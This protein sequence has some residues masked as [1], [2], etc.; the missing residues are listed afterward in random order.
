MA[1]GNPFEAPDQTAQ[2]PTQGQAQTQQP[3]DNS[4]AG[5]TP[6]EQ[7]QAAWTGLGW[8]PNKANQYRGQ[9]QQLV[10]YMAQHGGGQWGTGDFKRADDWMQ[11]PSGK[12]WD[13]ITSGGQFVQNPDNTGAPGAGSGSDAPYQPTMGYTPWAPN[14]RNNALYNMLM[15]RA[16]EGLDVSAKDPVIANQVNAFGAEQDRSARNY[17]R[18]QAEAGGPQSN[19]SMEGR[20]AS[21]KAG[22]A[23]GQLQ[24]QLMQNERNARRQEIQAAISQ[25]GGM[26]SQDQMMALQ[27]ELAY[28][29]NDQFLN[30]MDLARH[31]QAYNEY[32]GQSGA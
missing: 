3:K 30:Q 26:L 10:D 7:M 20:M 6:Q 31:S 27:K 1:T 4:L 8:D 19:M 2:Q 9:Q 32:M 5:K 28:L 18:Q 22:Q 16:Q 17:M 15:G 11:D 24:S 21:E 13:I 14:E 12:S 23:T 25:L 29:S